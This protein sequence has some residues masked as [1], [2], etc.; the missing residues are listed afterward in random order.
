MT[1]SQPGA[2]SSA[3][4]GNDSPLAANAS[5]LVR[6]E[7][8]SS[9]E[10]EFARWAVAYTCGRARSPTRAA[11]AN[12]TGVSSTTVASRL[13][14]AVVSAATANTPPSSRTGRPRQARATTSP[15]AVNRP[16]S[17]H[18]CDS[19]STAAR[20]PTTGSSVLVCAHACAGDTAPTATSSPAAGTAAT[21]SGQSRGRATANASTP[22]SRAAETISAAIEFRAD[23]PSGGCGRWR[24][25]RG[26]CRPS[27]YPR[28]AA[29][30]I[31]GAR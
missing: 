17:A 23:L 3:K 5:R 20:N 10:A 7:T 14:T 8:G 13:S 28:L 19:V 25:R 31:P 4:R 30:G 26:H 12:T 1:S 21:A 9:S 6:L 18:S 29:P 27:S 22:T 16:S 11:V 24:P 2:I 15:A